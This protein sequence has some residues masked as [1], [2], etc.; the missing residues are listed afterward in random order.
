MPSRGCFYFRR[1]FS[2]CENSLEK[3]LCTKNWD[4]ET[5]KW[6]KE[7]WQQ[8]HCLQI[9]KYT[10]NVDFLLLSFP[11]HLSHGLP[12]SCKRG[13]VV[14]NERHLMEVVGPP[15]Q[16]GHHRESIFQQVAALATFSFVL[17]QF[18][19]NKINNF[20]ICIYRGSAKHKFK[21]FIRK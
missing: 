21:F 12:Q 4:F 7:L 5:L 10:L 18:L 2:H 1:L 14:L 15:R 8:L 19:K 6:S 20:D 16:A 17:D 3:W 9:S 11:A 13:R